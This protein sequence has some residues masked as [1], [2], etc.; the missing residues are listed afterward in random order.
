VRQQIGIAL[1]AAAMLA[2]LPAAAEY[3]ERDIKVICGFPAGTGADTIVRY[4][5]NELSKQAGKTVIVEN[6]PGALSNVGAKSA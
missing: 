5:S 4:F 1:A 2:A 6:R 3:P